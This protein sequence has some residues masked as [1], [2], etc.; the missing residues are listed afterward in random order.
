VAGAW[1]W[2][3]FTDRDPR[4]PR[5][6]A[7]R[8]FA[9]SAAVPLAAVALF[10]GLVALSRWLRGGLPPGRRAAGAVDGAPGR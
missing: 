1:V 8:V 5:P 4:P 6:G 10:T 7:W 9:I 3:A 2:R